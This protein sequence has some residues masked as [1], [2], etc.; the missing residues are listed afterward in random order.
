[1]SEQQTPQPIELVMHVLSMG[2]LSYASYHSP[3]VQKYGWVIADRFNLLFLKQE[4]RDF[5]NDTKTVSIGRTVHV[6]SSNSSGSS[7]FERQ[8]SNLYSTYNNTT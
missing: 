1:M 6:A 7:L 3:N 5:S 8:T 2:R 4:Y